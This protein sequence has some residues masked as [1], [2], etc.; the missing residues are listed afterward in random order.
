MTGKEGMGYG[1]FKMFAA[2]GAWFGWT[3]IPAVILLSSII[4]SIVGISMIVFAKQGKNIPIPFGPYLAIGGI[5]SLFWGSQ[6]SHLYFG[7]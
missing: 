6:L 1:D 2:I 4:G 7:G 3:M 5:A